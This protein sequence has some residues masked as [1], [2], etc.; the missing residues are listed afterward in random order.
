[1]LPGLLGGC[2]AA[3]LVAD[4]PVLLE[5]IAR[6]WSCVFVAVQVSRGSPG[7]PRGTDRDD[8]EYDSGWS[9]GTACVAIR[10]VDVRAVFEF[11][12]SSVHWGSVKL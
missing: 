3:T 1:M 7:P 9:D 10:A 5:R 4:A 6:L 2:C 11:V 8:L 12:S